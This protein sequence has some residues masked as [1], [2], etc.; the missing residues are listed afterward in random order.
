MR[1]LAILW[2]AVAFAISGSTLANPVMVVSEVYVEQFPGTTHVQ[3]TRTYSM[4]ASSAMSVSRDGNSVAIVF[5][6]QPGGSRDLGSGMSS[7]TTAVGCDCS[8]AIGKHTYVVANSNVELDVLEA[9]AATGTARVPS[10]ECNVK[11]ES[12]VPIPAATGGSS[13]VSAGGGSSSIG[14]GGTF[15]GSANSSGNPSGCTV[16]RAAG[17]LLPLGVLAALGLLA[18]RRRK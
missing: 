18:L 4:G 6:S 5:D 10:A 11:C 2:G 3:V 9:S 14:A 16:S 13:A 7:L 17:G 8:V 1:S 15:D 12:A